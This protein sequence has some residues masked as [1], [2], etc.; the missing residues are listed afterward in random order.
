MNEGI[1]VWQPPLREPVQVHCQYLDFVERATYL[2]DLP[3][4]PWTWHIE[5]L[6]KQNV[7]SL[8]S[9]APRGSFE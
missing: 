1:Q 3:G 9:P 2:W 8:H 4:E 7:V 5:S 6:T